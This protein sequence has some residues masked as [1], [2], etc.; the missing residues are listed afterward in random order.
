MNEKGLPINN[1][2]RTFKIAIRIKENKEHKDDN[3]DT[4]NSKKRSIAPK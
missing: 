2:S 3:N 1:I 4:N